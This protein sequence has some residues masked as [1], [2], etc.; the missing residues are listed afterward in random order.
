MNDRIRNLKDKLADHLGRTPVNQIEWLVERSRKATME[1]IQKHQQKLSVM[2]SPDWE[3]LP[4]FAGD[5]EYER[6]E[7]QIE[8]TK[9]ELATEIKLLTVLDLV[10]VILREHENGRAARDIVD[11]LKRK[12]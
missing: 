12:P 10:G 7:V 8:N 1:V 5:N 4:Q 11:F 2:Q 6:R 9:H 3:P